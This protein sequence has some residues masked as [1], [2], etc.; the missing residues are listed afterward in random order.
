MT[1][2]IK[3]KFAQL[4]DKRSYFSEGVVSLPFSH[5]LLTKLINLK[6]DFGKKIE[7]VILEKKMKC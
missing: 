7:K 1:S 4:N 5:P 2:I 6:K 3:S